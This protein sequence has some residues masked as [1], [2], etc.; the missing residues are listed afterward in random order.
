M[1]TAPLARIFFL[2]IVSF[3]T[4]SFS[5]PFSEG[6]SPESFETYP[7]EKLFCGKK[8]TLRNDFYQISPGAKVSHDFNLTFSVKSPHADYE[9]VNLPKLVKLLKEIPIIEDLKKKTMSDG[10]AEGVGDS[11]KGAGRG[12]ALLASHPV[13]T[14][15]NIGKAAGKLFKSTGRLFKPINQKNV[16]KSSLKDKLL[17]GAKRDIANKIG[18]DIYSSNPYLQE[19]L[20]RVAKGQTG[21]RTAFSI[22]TFFIPVGL[23]GNIAMTASGVSEAA[24]Q[25]ANT[26]DADELYDLNRKAF[27]EMGFGEKDIN[28]FLIENPY[29]NPR[30]QTRVRFYLE[31]LKAVKGWETIFKQCAGS[32]S[33]S[34]ADGLLLSLEMLVLQAEKRKDFSLIGTQDGIL[35]AANSRREGLVFLPYDFLFLNKEGQELVQKLIKVKEKLSARHLTAFNLGSVTSAMRS[36]LE[37]SGISVKDCL[38]GGEMSK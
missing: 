25:M 34:E 16:K 5:L 18:V 28:S 36:S 4:L 23:V 3:L 13:E 17:E 32:Q 35:Y 37:S 20:E 9:V 21:G 8:I 7:V 27:L 14:S 2:T 19:E 29:F 26:K 31:S 11:I 22:V 1:N 30:E 33:Q 15:K 24:D 10:A 12:F 6:D 38:F